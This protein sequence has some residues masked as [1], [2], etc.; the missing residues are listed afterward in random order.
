VGVDCV[1]DGLDPCPAHPATKAAA[2]N[3]MMGDR[4]ALTFS[5]PA[6]LSHA[7]IGARL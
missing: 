4:I 3:K 5:C 7:T 1:A 6:R 2:I